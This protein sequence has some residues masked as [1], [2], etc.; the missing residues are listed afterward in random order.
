[1]SLNI[2]RP[3]MAL[4]WRWVPEKSMILNW[5]YK[6]S[7]IKGPHISRFAFVGI[8]VY[9]ILLGRSLFCFLKSKQIICLL[10]GRVR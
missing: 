2:N 7:Q 1:M 5:T 3:R 9:R 8:K 4:N 6:K 10:E